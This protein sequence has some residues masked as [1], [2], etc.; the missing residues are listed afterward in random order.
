MC[1]K[2]YW[3]KYKMFQKLIFIIPVLSWSI[4]VEAQIVPPALGEINTSGWLALG[5]KQK[6]DTLSIKG[7]ESVTYAG[8]GTT[9]QTPRSNPFEN[10]GIGV[11]NQEFYRHL[12][13][14][15][16]YSL[17][18]S[19]RQQYLPE[20]TPRYKQE[21][22]WYGRI[23]HTFQGNKWEITPTFRQEAIKYF[24]PDF[25]D[26]T[27]S[28]RLRSRFRLKFALALNPDRSQQ[29]IAYSEQLFSTSRY[30]ETKK[31]SSFTYTDSRFALYYS[32]APAGQPLIY[33]LGYMHHLHG[34]KNTF[35]G[36]YI[37]LDIIWK[38]PLHR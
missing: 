10:L 26:Y 30:N 28:W 24:T 32:I 23:S 36:H 21:F 7:W 20:N 14:N 4:P 18:L 6:L 27:E 19:Y 9:N 1:R 2:A 34:T 5:V 33:N 3:E 37:A 15:W 12:P 16:H 35:S 11:L 22:R 17:A 8:I 31:W 29:L 25:E 38:N 13:K